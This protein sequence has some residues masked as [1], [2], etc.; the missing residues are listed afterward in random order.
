M[1]LF[2][3]LSVWEKLEEWSEGLK[4]W[5]FA[6]YSNPLLWIGIVGGGFLIFKAVFSA[7]NT[8]R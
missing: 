6:N 5:I 1:N 4:Q 7:L 3:V 2:Q 8:E